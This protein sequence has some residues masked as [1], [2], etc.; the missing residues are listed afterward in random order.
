MVG[1]TEVWEIVNLTADAHPIHTHLTQFQLMNRQN[2]NVNKYNGAYNAAFPGGLFIGGY[3]PPLD[4]NTGNLRALGGNPDITPY[5]QG[6]VQ[7]PL[8]QEAGWKDTVIMYPGQVTRIAVR[9]APTDFA[10]GLDINELKY[11]F[12]TNAGGHG[13]VWH[14]HIIDHE[15]NEMMRPYAVMPRVA[16]ATQAKQQPDPNQVN[17]SAPTDT[18]TSEPSSEPTATNE[19]GTSP[20]LLNQP[21]SQL[22]LP[23]APQQSNPPSSQP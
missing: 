11:P 12:D 17:E 6:A 20:P 18:P 8:P 13:F 14:C 4:Y 22:Q 5:L 19:A 23:P 7:P 16:L 10:T 21:V 1:D 9:Y 15:D 3:G 2:F